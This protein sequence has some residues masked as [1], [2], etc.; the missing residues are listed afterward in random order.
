M[1]AN[2]RGAWSIANAR[3]T[4]GYE[5]RDNSEVVYADEIRRYIVEPARA[6]MV[7]GEARGGKG[8]R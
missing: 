8:S 5:P 3:K 1:S 4:V 6:S 7:R 2:T